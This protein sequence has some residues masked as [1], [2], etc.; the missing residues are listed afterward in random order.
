MNHSLVKILITSLLILSCGGK[1]KTSQNLPKK[2]S[3]EKHWKTN[4]GVGP[5]TNITLEAINLDIAKEG[6]ALYKSKCIA[7]HRTTTKR[8]IGPGLG[9]IM[10]RRTPEWTMNMIINPQKMIKEDPIGI[11]LYDKYKTPMLGLGIDEKE[12]R[13]ILE[14]LR[15]L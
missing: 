13:I 3:A 5:V 9:K 10:A 2:E 1:D 8:L 6:E 12:A 11:E 7:C 15:T 4:K 14:Y